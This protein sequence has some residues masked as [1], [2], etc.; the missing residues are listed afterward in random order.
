LTGGGEPVVP[1][2]TTEASTAAS[3]PQSVALRWFDKAVRVG[4]VVGLVISGVSI[5]L[6]V[7][8]GAVDTAGR[9]FFNQ[10][11][12]GTVELTEALLAV[13]ICTALAY[14]QQRGEHV[15]VDIVTQFFGKRAN[16]ILHAIALGLTLV[17]FAFLAWRSYDMAAHAWAVGETSAGYFRIPVWLSK[18]TAT[19]GFV[20]VTLETLRQV[21][22]LCAGRDVQT[23]MKTAIQEQAHH[24]VYE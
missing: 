10:P 9:A 7:I 1:P 16:Q 15:S 20:M 24:A 12:L 5:A 2:Q 18:A 19:F 6:I 22:W 4:V 23:E 11:F 3:G 21:L 13:A 14:A 8:I 17:V